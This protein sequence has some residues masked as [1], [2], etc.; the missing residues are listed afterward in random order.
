MGEK[1]QYIKCVRPN[2]FDGSQ[3]QLPDRKPLIFWDED[4]KRI[5]ENGPQKD[6]PGISPF[7]AQSCAK[8]ARFSCVASFLVGTDLPGWA[9]ACMVACTSGTLSSRP[10]DGPLPGPHFLSGPSSDHWSM[11]LQIDRG[12]QEKERRARTW[13]DA[14][15]AASA[16]TP[17]LRATMGLGSSRWVIDVEPKS[18][19]SQRASRPNAEPHWLPPLQGRGTALNPVSTQL[20]Q[21]A[22]PPAPFLDLSLFPLPTSRAKPHDLLDIT[23]WTCEQSA[24]T[25]F[26]FVQSF[27]SR[28]FGPTPITV[29]TPISGSSTRHH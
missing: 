5:P 13:A 11:H 21:V 3:E 2:A 4:E 14:Q 1:T 15:N 12:K 8:L 19:S 7:P 10:R 18:G 26:S 22:A 24:A 6:K 28:S 25:P 20:L 9:S 27:C 29:T 16:A 23:V 17:A